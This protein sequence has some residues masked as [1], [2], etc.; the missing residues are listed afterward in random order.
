[1]RD[2][3]LTLLL[4][5]ERP[6][7]VYVI[8]AKTLAPLPYPTTDVPAEPVTGGGA[9]TLY[10]GMNLGK[11]WLR[12]SCLERPISLWLQFFAVKSCLPKSSRQSF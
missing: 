7:V 8:G 12:P 10:P 6:N 9:I 5:T 11:S 4:K 3:I 1:M 2:P